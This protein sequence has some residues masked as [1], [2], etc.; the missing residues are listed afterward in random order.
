M[1]GIDLKIS[2]NVTVFS[3]FFMCQCV[4]EYNR[5]YLDSGEFI[6]PVVSFLYNSP[7]LAELHKFLSSNSVSGSFIS[8][9]PPPLCVP[10][11]N[12]LAVAQTNDGTWVAACLS[13]GSAYSEGI[14]LAKPESKCFGVK[15][16]TELLGFAL[17]DVSVVRDLLCNS[18]MN[19]IIG[20]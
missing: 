20:T 14:W 17:T 19:Q 12:S 5:L 6:W 18:L 3:S 9:N 15:Q 11:S 4:P 7:S 10:T 13:A 2:K 1:G 8:A 16:F